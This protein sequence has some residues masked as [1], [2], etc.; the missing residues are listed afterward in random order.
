M[1]ISLTEL[2]IDELY[3]LRSEVTQEI[4]SRE[5]ADRVAEQIRDLSMQLLDATGREMQAAWVQPTGAHDA[6]PEG[7]EVT[8][9]DKIW[10]SLIAG[11][12][13]EPGVSGWR[14]VT[15]DG[16]V[17]EWVQPTG[18]HDSYSLGAEVMHAGKNWVSL[19]DANVWRP[20]DA[21]TETLWEEVVEESEEP[22][23]PE[24]PAE[25]E[26]PGEPSVAEWN[27]NGLNYTSDAQ[28]T[29]EGVTYVCLQPHTSQPGWTSLRCVFDGW[30]SAHEA[31]L[32]A[33]V[34][35]SRPTL[36]RLVPAD[37]AHPAGVVGSQALRPG[38]F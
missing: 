36:S 10:T 31:L 33:D 19:V 1:D 22:T 26:E 35:A 23:D 4:D 34:D 38:V 37:P 12:V 27:P 2:T 5:K 16:T 6:Y 14:E 8:H 32:P 24:E 18:T 28:V 29:F 21:G 13:F 15:T 9:N 20:G 30:V 25:P 11:N 17:A 7:W 3:E